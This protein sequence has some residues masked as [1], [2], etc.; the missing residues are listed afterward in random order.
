MLKTKVAELICRLAGGPN[1]A[2][3]VDARNGWPAIVDLQLSTGPKRF[4]LHAGAAHSMGR[5]KANEYRFQNPGD[6]TPVQTI[7]GHPPLLIG[8]WNT[9]E[10]QPILVAAEAA[11]RLGDRTRQSYLF[12]LPQVRQ[13]Q[14]MGWVGPHLNTSQQ[15]LYFF[16]PSLLPT[17]AE[18]TLAGVDIP[19]HTVQYAIDG[20]GLAL[21]PQ[22]PEAAA[23]VRH[24]STRLVRSAKFSNDVIA[25][26]NNRCAMCGL[27][28][29]LVSGAH[30]LP[31]AATESLAFDAIWNGVCLCDNHHRAFDAHHVHVDPAS[32]EITLDERLKR[33]ANAEDYSRIFVTTTFTKLRLPQD[34]S[35]YPREDMFVERYAHYGGRYEWLRSS[36]G[37]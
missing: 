21:E 15:K 35:L 20:A 5:Y 1:V 22:S 37:T 19:Q 8:L 28:L 4:S 29:G 23:R 2:R 6:K 12:H 16:Y 10:E 31:V 3:V 32:Y 13:A 14:M 17:F 9:D 7:G 30:I 11:L 25:A 34:S 26:Y 24:S 36:R 27:N 18:L 33:I